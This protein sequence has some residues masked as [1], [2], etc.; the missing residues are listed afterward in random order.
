MVESETVLCPVCGWSGTKARLTADGEQY[1]CPACSSQI[2][3]GWTQ[4]GVTT[5]GLTEW[6][7]SLS[8]T[9]CVTCTDRFS[10]GVTTVLLPLL[11]SVQTWLRRSEQRRIALRTV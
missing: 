1:Q 4:P 6:P 11:Y 5:T 7:A 9:K 8:Y 2:R 3:S 10:L